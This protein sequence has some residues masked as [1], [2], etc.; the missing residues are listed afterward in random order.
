MSR[1][2]NGETNQYKIR[3]F[4]DG[5]GTITINALSEQEARDKFYNGEYSEDQDTD[6]SENYCIDSVVQTS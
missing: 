2:N 6:Q 3:Y 4:F 1:T 5:Q